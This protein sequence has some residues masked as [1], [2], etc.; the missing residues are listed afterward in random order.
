[1]SEEVKPL[2]TRK[3]IVEGKFAEVQKLIFT[4]GLTVGEIASI[5]NACQNN[6]NNLG[7]NMNMPAPIAPPVAEEVKPEVK[8]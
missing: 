1:M 6:L 8:E 4:S 7:V 3:E 5:I 2:I